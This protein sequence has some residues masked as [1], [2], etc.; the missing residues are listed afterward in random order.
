MNLKNRKKLSIIAAGLAIVLVVCAV[1]LFGEKKERGIEQGN[2]LENGDFSA[3]TNGM[4]DGWQTGMWVT[5]AGASYLEAVQTEDAV[6]AVLVENVAANDVRFEQTVAVRE[7]ATYRLSARVKAEDCDS[8]QL[9]ANVSFLGVFGTSADV[10]DTDGEWETIEVYAHT[11]K[12]QKSLTACVRLGGYGSEATGRAWFTDVVLEQVESAPV[13]AQVID[14]TTPEPQKETKPKEDGDKA[15]AIP[16]LL[17][18]A[19]AYGVAAF[20]LV[21]TL[22][23]GG[24]SEDKRGM[25]KLI[26]VLLGALILRLSL[27]GNVRGYGVDMGCFGAWAGKMSYG[28]PANFY[29]EGYFC[30]YPPAYLLV[31][32]LL[33]H[34]ANLFGISF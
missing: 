25:I 3:V 9:G 7:N 11:G 33:S 12:G 5:S 6:S 18:V 24:V 28:G 8:A 13:G 21:R 1:M 22:M 26:I 2:L 14:L 29:E 10:H 20:A 34:L 15:A 32:G 16:L 27:A 23:A 17:L 4:P 19:A 31:L 30:D